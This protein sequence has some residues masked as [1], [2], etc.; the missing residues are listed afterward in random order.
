M[1]RRRVWI[2]VI[3][4]LVFLAGIAI[5]LATMIKQSPEFYSQADVEPGSE[6]TRLSQE[7]VREYFGVTR[8]LDEPN[9][10]VVSTAEQINAFFQEDYYKLGGD[11]NLPEGFHAPR[12]S[13]QKDRIVLGAQYGG[14]FFTTVLWVELRIWKVANELNTLAM[15]VIG[16]RAGSLPL[17]TGTL[18][19]QVSE[20]AR[21]QHIEIS[22]YRND[23]HPVAIM[24]FHTDLSR[25]TF[26]FDRV[27]LEDGL[28]RV[29]GR[30]TTAADLP[31]PPPVP[32]S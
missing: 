9:W 18:L 5:G 14:G 27:E 20:W 2:S 19:D 6:R 17:S 1:P 4:V 30:S 8:L 32:D 21:Q 11:D 29:R 24:R 7:L 12:V 25:P 16:L 10:D 22:W 28:L 26:Q 23:G 31:D 15:E 3:L 13:I